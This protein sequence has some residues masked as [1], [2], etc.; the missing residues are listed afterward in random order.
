MKEY[1][2]ESY[3]ELVHKVTWPTWSELQSSSILVLIASVIIALLIFLMDWVFGVNA[4]EGAT[5]TG[6]KG[7]LGYIYEI[8][9]N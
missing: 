3:E 7:V 4:I 2:I 1:I 5:S 8:L 9:I 6:W